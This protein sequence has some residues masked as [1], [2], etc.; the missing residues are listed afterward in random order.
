MRFR[1]W[2]L[3]FQILFSCYNIMSVRYPCPIRL[4]LFR[5]RL[6]EILLRGI[7]SVLER[8]V[9][10]TS[11][12][13]DA[14]HWLRISNRTLL[15]SYFRI[16]SGDFMVL[17][18][19]ILNK[20]DTKAVKL[21]VDCVVEWRVSWL[22]PVAASL[23]I[24][25]I[26]ILS[27]DLVNLKF[28]RSLGSLISFSETFVSWRSFVRPL[29]SIMIRLFDLILPAQSLLFYVFLHIADSCLMFCRLLCL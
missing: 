7:F 15:Q 2:I 1:C 19:S 26:L 25:L 10:G 27:L 6:G 16:I 20:V 9:Y 11:T 14:C 17:F 23:E 29:V 12:S 18:L 28:S 24:L 8:V 3:A 5:M 21:V 4:I 13:D 22:L